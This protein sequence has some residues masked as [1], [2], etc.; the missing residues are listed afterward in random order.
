MGVDFGATARDYARYRT[1]FPAEFFGRL[2]ALGVGLAGHRVVD[3]GTGTGVLA[4]GLAAAGCTVT[5]V[6]I[7][8]ELL[9]EAQ[10]Q[11]AAAGLKTTYR[12]APAEETGLPSG[13]WDVVSAGHCWHWFDRLRTAAEA[14]RLLAPN[15][16]IVICYRD[17]L[18]EPGNVCDAS[19]ELA[20]SYNSDWPMSGGIS[21][22]PEWADELVSAGFKDLHAFSFDVTVS[23]T[24]EAWRGRM[25]SSSGI[26]ASLPQAQVKAFDTELARLLKDRFPHEPLEIPH[27]ISALI[28]RREQQD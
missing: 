2:V 25:R 19:E 22:H 16:A 13:S 20:F 3:L 11:D 7:A 26:G 9:E 4:R 27:R 28:G 15:G 12:L 23:F 6:D 17:H 21:D 24:H 5:G 1:E 14:R 8:P 10:R 18:I